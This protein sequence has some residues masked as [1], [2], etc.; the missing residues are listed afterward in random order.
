LD[1]IRLAHPT[2]NRPEPAPL[3][4]KGPACWDRAIGEWCEAFSGATEVDA[5][6]H[7]TILAAF[8]ERDAIGEASYGVRLRPHDG[9]NSLVDATQELMDALVYFTKWQMETGERLPEMGDLRRM[10]FGL[11]QRVKETV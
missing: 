5:E 9:R 10:I 6:M 4:V 3:P 8:R 2:I 11:F 7:L 1:P